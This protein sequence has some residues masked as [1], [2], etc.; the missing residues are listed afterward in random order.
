MTFEKKNDLSYKFAEFLSLRQEV[1][2][3]LERFEII[4]CKEIN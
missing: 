3:N 1:T 4:P 2:D